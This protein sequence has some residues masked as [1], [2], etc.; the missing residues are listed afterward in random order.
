MT[1]P[2]QT[3]LEKTQKILEATR[4]NCERMVEKF[5]A[6]SSQ[7]SLLLNRI[8]ALNVTEKVLHP[9]KNVMEVSSADLA[10]AL[11]PLKSIIQKCK[12]GQE[13]HE[14]GNT[15]YQR[16]QGIINAMEMA[17]G[18]VEARSQGD[19]GESTR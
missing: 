12:K 19:K 11:P 10:R 6:G 15:T 13:K 3:E 14:K 16:L 7:H 5:P 17:V 18:E 4:M 1:K 8:Y 2:I 9:G